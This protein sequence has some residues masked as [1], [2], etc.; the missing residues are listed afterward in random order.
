[1]GGNASHGRN[2]SL[3]EP[4]RRS[5]FSCVM[6]F[7]LPSLCVFCSACFVLCVFCAL[8]VLLTRAEARYM[9]LRTGES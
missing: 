5:I 9:I 3:R 7:A 6:Y 1:L 4:P 2:R 8:R